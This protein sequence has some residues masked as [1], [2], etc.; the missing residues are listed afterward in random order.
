MVAGA[1]GRNGGRAEG[2]PADE[3]APRETSAVPPF[4]PS[5]PILVLV[6]P[7]DIV[8]IASAVRIARNFGIERMRLVNPEIFDP[9]RIEGIA[10]NSADF[11]AGIEI[12]DSLDAAVAD[13]VHVA[14]LTARGRTAKRRTVRP[15]E[16]AAELVSAAA[17]GPVAMVVGRED[18]GLT[19]AELDLG[20]VLV[21]IPTDPANS[22]LNLAQAVAIMAYESWI[23]RGGETAP[24]KPPRKGTPP[25]TSAQLE[26]LFG[27]WRRAL[28]AVDFFK[29]RR[30]ESVMRSFRE[31]VHRAAL[32]GREASLVRA[33]GI[34][35]VRY[36]ARA[37]LTVSEPPL[38]DPS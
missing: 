21:T 15:R 10:H 33:M 30:S 38:A 3:S 35:V 1:E 36:L 27:D 24:L 4:R 37:G 22:S 31:I 29:T 16:A 12:V 19:N 9:W 28:W 7:Q 2:S 13:C 23:A 17:T 11:V 25:A 5:A 18:R 14:V 6:N 26:E 20:H 8:N 32:D 34:E